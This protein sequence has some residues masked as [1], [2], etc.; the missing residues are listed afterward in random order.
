M[1]EVRHWLENLCL[2]IH[3]PKI[4]KFESFTLIIVFVDDPHRSLMPVLPT[5]V[6]Y[7]PELT[8]RLSRIVGRLASACVRLC[9]WC[10][11]LVPWLLW[12]LP[13]G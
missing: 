10:L 11:E 6:R 7:R 12:L 2:R 8:Y 5:R 13:R 4:P 1:R 3:G 9:L